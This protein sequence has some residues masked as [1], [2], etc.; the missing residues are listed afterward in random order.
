MTISTTR[1]LLVPKPIIRELCHRFLLYIVNCFHNANQKQNK[2][3]ECACMCTP[4]GAGID[5]WAFNILAVHNCDNI[6]P[7]IS[8]KFYV[9]FSYT[10]ILVVI[11]HTHMWH[12][13]LDAK[14]SFCVMCMCQKR[15][16][17]WDKWIRVLTSHHILIIYW[18]HQYKI[19]YWW[20]SRYIYWAVSWS[21]SCIICM[22]PDLTLASLGV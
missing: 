1:S 8:W 13:P 15:C 9:H 17:Q 12:T 6:V 7:L 14:E 5:K 4:D 10:V 11:T 22:S 2:S 19:S 20:W 16:Q 21:W 18:A 3:N